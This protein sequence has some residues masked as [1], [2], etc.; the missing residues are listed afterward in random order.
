MTTGARIENSLRQWK[1]RSTHLP[2]V[3]GRTTQASLALQE[4]NGQ[5]GR[6]AA[7]GVDPGAADAV[8]GRDGGTAGRASGKAYVDFLKKRVFT[9]LGM[10]SRVWWRRDR[11][12]RTA[13]S[14]TSSKTANMSRL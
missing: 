2:C 14:A 12:T 4:R 1:R 13:P 5:L 10:H 7:G 9:P 11:R 6:F 8:A 3:T